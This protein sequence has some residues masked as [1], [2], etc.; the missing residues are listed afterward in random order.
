MNKTEEYYLYTE[1]NR[2]HNY[3]EKLLFFLV[4]NNDLGRSESES[5]A[6]F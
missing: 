3:V 4:K 6:Q 1:E 2:R 5:Y